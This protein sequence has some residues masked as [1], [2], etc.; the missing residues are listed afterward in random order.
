MR[1]FSTDLYDK[2][3]E[4]GA[5]LKI[6][7]KSEKTLSQTELYDVATKIREFILTHAEEMRNLNKEDRTTIKDGLLQFKAKY[8]KNSN[9]LAGQAIACLS[10]I[11]KDVRNNKDIHVDDYDV[12][13]PLFHAVFRG[14]M[15]ALLSLFNAGRTADFKYVNGYSLI[16]CFI[17]SETKNPQILKVLLDHG[18]LAVPEKIAVYGFRDFCALL[19]S[20]YTPE[21]GKVLAE[22]FKK[23]TH[24]TKQMEVVTYF[25]FVSSAL[26]F[27][28]ICINLSVP[29]MFRSSENPWKM[30][31]EEKRRDLIVKLSRSSILPEDLLNPDF[32]DVSPL[33]RAL[34][35]N[36]ILQAEF[37]IAVGS[38]LEKIDPY[39]LCE[40]YKKDE[41]LF[42]WIVKKLGNNIIHIRTEKNEN[43]LFAMLS[44]KPTD[45]VRWLNMLG[46]LVT[47]G[48]SVTQKDSLFFYSPLDVAHMNLMYD[49]AR[50]LSM[51][52]LYDPQN[53]DLHNAVLAQNKAE[54]VRTIQESDD[55]FLLNSALQR[56]FDLVVEKNRLDLV[57]C[58][59]RVCNLE[60]NKVIGSTRNWGFTHYPFYNAL[61][62]HHYEMAAILWDLNYQI[63]LEELELI[64]GLDM[65]AKI[66]C[67]YIRSTQPRS[68]LLKDACCSN[69][70]KK[71]KL[72]LQ[73]DP[74]LIDAVTKNK[75]PIQHAFENRAWEVVNE[76]L[77]R[78]PPLPSLEE[79]FYPNNYEAKACYWSFTRVLD[80]LIA[81]KDREGV[82]LLLKHPK[83]QAIV[84]REGIARA[85]YNHNPEVIDEMLTNG[86]DVNG[87]FLSNDIRLDQIAYPLSVAVM[88]G[89]TSLVLKLVEHG[90]KFDLNTLF[91]LN[92]YQWRLKIQLQ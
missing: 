84:L 13:D 48:V 42:L 55:V 2:E 60:E 37:W 1:S 45:R 52:L 88:L 86:F 78:Y 89:D 65:K 41:N 81:K 57:P 69:E 46:Y 63:S 67:E 90:G 14:D 64:C 17:N 23:N 8:Y 19:E 72:L 22:H 49:A 18:A 68:S 50:V 87:V 43:V 26:D 20:C 25:I 33:A 30:L 56:P 75:L 24:T 16:Q 40:H 44:L 15:E 11:F 85:I 92:T 31:Y 34:S 51:Q 28:E 27:L 77:D 61:R 39:S 5:D 6:H 47:L 66:K 29:L 71:V 82:M 32:F 7:R 10:D 80:G 53:S 62:L 83:F 58:F 79:L 54:V 70:V 9:F 21:I 74:W 91:V 35:K 76:L 38:K 36:D 4:L 59:I 3:N 12:L 73:Q